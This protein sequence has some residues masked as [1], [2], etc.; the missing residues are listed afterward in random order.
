MLIKASSPDGFYRKPYST[1][2]LKLHTKKISETRK[3]KSIHEK[4]FVEQKNHTK[5]LVWEDSRLC[6]ETSTKNYISEKMNFRQFSLC[7][8]GGESE[9]AVS[10]HV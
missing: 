7:L 1:L 5:T 9:E 6:P 8:P 2:V 3:L 4:Q 10:G